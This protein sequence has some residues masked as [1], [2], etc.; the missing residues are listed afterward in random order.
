MQGDDAHVGK[1]RNRYF[2]ISVFITGI[3]TV[4]A[5]ALYGVFFG[6][7]DSDVLKGRT[8]SARAKA[9]TVLELPWRGFPEL[10]DVERRILGSVIDRRFAVFAFDLRPF[11][12]IYQDTAVFAFRKGLGLE[13]MQRADTLLRPILLNDRIPRPTPGELSNRAKADLETAYSVLNAV[14]SSNVRWPVLYNLGVIEFWRGNYAAAF[15]NFKKSAARLA[16]GRKQISEGKYSSDN[17]DKNEARIV[18]AEIATNYAMALTT[19]RELA[20]SES[21]QM[22]LR[23]RAGILQFWQALA[24]L[25]RHLKRTPNSTYDEFSDLKVEPLGLRVYSI[26]NDLIASLLSSRVVACPP[27]VAELESDCARFED[28][29]LAAKEQLGTR[30]HREWFGASPGARTPSANEDVGLITAFMAAAPLLK[31]EPRARNDRLLNHN[32]ALMLALLERYEQ[33]RRRLLLIDPAERGGSDREASFSRLISLMSAAVDGK[34]LQQRWPQSRVAAG[35]T[36]PSRQAYRKAA[37]DRIVSGNGFPPFAETSLF[38]A[39]ESEDL[40]HF[41]FFLEWRRL[42][43][44]SHDGLSRFFDTV[45][46]LED[47][48]ILLSTHKDWIDAVTSEAVRRTFTLMRRFEAQGRTEEAGV[49]KSV[50]IEIIRERRSLGVL[51]SSLSTFSVEILALLGSGILAFA[52]GLYFLHRLVFW[53]WFARPR[54]ASAFESEHRRERLAKRRQADEST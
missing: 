40:D 30:Q 22:Q 10:T 49:A 8:D 43:S 13:E 17:K 46:Q 50:A 48:D 6:D 28:T 7:A 29:L 42:I 39:K 31:R 15:E 25:P 37:S 11:L 47:R 14:P 45:R 41:L 12:T 20:G 23:L 4:A 18:M 44:G 5:A 3:L 19:V 9:Q 24:L 33:A 1:Y 16:V 54:F 51:V 38:T 32:L 35:R 2:I 27:A 36:S 52:A 34:A 21:R 26:W 53:F